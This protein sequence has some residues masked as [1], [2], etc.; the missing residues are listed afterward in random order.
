MKTLK[1]K[2]N[3]SESLWFLRASLR[4]ADYVLMPGVYTKAA[5]VLIV[6]NVIPLHF[7][8]LFTAKLAENLAQE[9][10]ELQQQTKPCFLN[11]VPCGLSLAD[12][13]S[14]CNKIMI[15]FLKNSGRDFNSSKSSKE[16]A[17]R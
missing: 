3:I 2:N 6:C 8:T 16:R 10:G 17:V 4:A 5:L 7:P 15:I 14:H 11:P 9:C 1:G 13:S 12:I